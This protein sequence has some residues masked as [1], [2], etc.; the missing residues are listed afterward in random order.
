MDYRQSKVGGTSQE[1]V[2]PKCIEI[3][4]DDLQVRTDDMAATCRRRVLGAKP[5]S[6]PSCKN[7]Q[8]FVKVAAVSTMVQC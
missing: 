6:N 7:S 4:S 1:M 8:M 2:D 3:M 5:A